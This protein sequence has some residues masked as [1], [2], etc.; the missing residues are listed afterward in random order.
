MRFLCPRHVPCSRDA[1]CWQLE[2]VQHDV[3]VRRR[4]GSGWDISW[5]TRR[6]DHV[7]CMC[8]QSIYI[9][10]T[11]PVQ[12]QETTETCS[13]AVIGNRGWRI[14]LITRWVHRCRW[15][16]ADVVTFL[17]MSSQGRVGGTRRR[18]RERGTG[19]GES[20]WTRKDT[21]RRVAGDGT[22]GDCLRP[23]GPTRRFVFLLFIKMDDLW[24]LVHLPCNPIMPVYSRA[25][26]LLSFLCVFF[27][28]SF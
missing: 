13:Y 15:R 5:I 19:R 17:N 20:K 6:R 7:S 11:V 25:A 16:F 12:S 28:S 22:N 1:W 18:V 27:C 8:V 14:A 21:G 4:G 2:A 26:L 24:Q 10:W 9:C 23:R 3:P